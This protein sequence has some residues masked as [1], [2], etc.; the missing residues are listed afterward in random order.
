M[1]NGILSLTVKRLDE[2]WGGT[3][4]GKD[5][6][7]VVAATEVPD[8]AII[9]VCDLDMIFAQAGRVKRPFLVGKQN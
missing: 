5:M 7:A 1:I 2:F 4:I 8:F 6:G 9:V 3:R